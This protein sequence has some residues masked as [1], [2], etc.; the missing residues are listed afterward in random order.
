MLSTATWSLILSA[1][2][3]AASRYSL[4]DALVSPL[5]RLASAFASSAIFLASALAIDSISLAS[6]SND[7]CDSPISA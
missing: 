4:T 7:I 2:P 3:M 5:M 6:F 1:C